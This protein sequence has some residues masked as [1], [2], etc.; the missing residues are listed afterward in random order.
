MKQLQAAQAA[1]LRTLTQSDYTGQHLLQ[2]KKQS[3]VLDYIHYLD[4]V[5]TLISENTSSVGE[6]A[7]TRQL[8][9]YQHGVRMRCV[10]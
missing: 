10:H 3:L 2:L 5:D 4:M 6:W 8:R 9:Y 7:W 1:A